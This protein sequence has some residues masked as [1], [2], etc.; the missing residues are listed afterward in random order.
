MACLLA[1]S[2]CV[3]VGC[4]LAS[5]GEVLWRAGQAGR[6]NTGPKGCRPKYGPELASNA[7]TRTSASHGAGGARFHSPSRSG[8][9]PPAPLRVAMGCMQR[10]PAPPLLWKLLLSRA[11]EALQRRWRQ[12]RFMLRYVL[13]GRTLCSFS[14]MIWLTCADGLLRHRLLLRSWGFRF[15]D[16]SLEYAMKAWAD[17]GPPLVLAR[18]LGQFHTSE[19]A[20]GSVRPLGC[21]GVHANHVSIEAACSKRGEGRFSTALASA[22]R[23]LRVVQRGMQ[24]AA[25]AARTAPSSMPTHPWP[26][27][28]PK[29]VKPRTSS[30]AGSARQGVQKA[31][32]VSPA[33]GDASGQPRRSRRCQ[34]S[35]FWGKPLRAEVRGAQC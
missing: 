18:P 32:S 28:L 9:S 1:H 12:R 19:F 17:L 16:S 21:H 2:C 14:P 26:G 20:D 3:C 13:I 25:A 22:A 7:F 35:V 24:A 5:S 4:Q 27:C 8:R 15:S 31:G 29:A 10:A 33:I 30:G 34:S 6:S 23:G 11:V